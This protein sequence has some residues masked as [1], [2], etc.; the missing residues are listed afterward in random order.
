LAYPCIRPSEM[1]TFLSDTE[2]NPEAI[3]SL[4][5]ELRS[6]TAGKYVLK[7]YE[8]HRPVDPEKGYVVMKNADRNRSFFGWLFGY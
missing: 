7:M 1:S 6:T 5:E 4:S 3:N 2:I 8:K